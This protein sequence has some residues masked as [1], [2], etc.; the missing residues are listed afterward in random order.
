M[1]AKLIIL[2]LL[3]FCFAL[4]AFSAGPPIP[5]FQ[6][7]YNITGYLEPSLGSPYT[8]CFDFTNTGTVLGFSNSG[9]WNVPS[10]SGGW[11]GEWYVDGDEIVIH[12]VASSTFIFSWKGSIINS[13]RISGRQVEFF[14]DGSTDTAGT[15]FGLKLTGACPAAVSSKVG[16]PAK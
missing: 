16:D 11:F 6:G 15:F 9:T 8:W 2:S 3:L 14:I 1:K 13:T 7:S 4:P 10:Y 12:G 5:K